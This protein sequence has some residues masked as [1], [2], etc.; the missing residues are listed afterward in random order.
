MTFPCRRQA[1]LRWTA[2]R[3]VQSHGVKGNKFELTL[4]DKD[5]FC[6]HSETEESHEA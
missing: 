6:E 1:G 2:P 4:L 3:N 5:T